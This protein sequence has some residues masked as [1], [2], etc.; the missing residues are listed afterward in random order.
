MY[1]P[2]D[3]E[4][5]VREHP[6]EAS[7]ALA[8]IQIGDE[9]P[10]LDAEG[11]NAAAR[12]FLS[13]RGEFW[14][15]RLDERQLLPAFARALTARGLE[16]DLGEDPIEITGVPPEVAKAF[17]DRA[18]QFRCRI[19]R[20]GAVSGSGVLVGPSTVLTAWHVVGPAAPYSPQGPIPAL[21]VLL[22]DGRRLRATLAEGSP[23]SP[24]EFESRLPANDNA[25]NALHDVALL[26]L[27]EP[28]GAQFGYATVSDPPVPY[29]RPGPLLLVHYPNGVDGGLGEGVTERI[30]GLRARV[31]HTVVSADGSSGGGCFDTRRLLV[32]VHQGRRPDNRGRFVPI[33]RFTDLIRRAIAADAAPPAMWSLDGTPRSPLVIGRTDFLSAYAAALAPGPVRG[34]RVRRT[35]PLADAAGLPFSHEM[36]VGLA[37]RDQGQRVVRVSFADRSPDV[38]ET[39]LRRLRDEGLAAGQARERPGVATGESAPEAV[40]ADV[41]KRAALLADQA[42]AAAGLTLWLF[43]DE[44]E[45]AFGDRQR[46]TLEGFIAQALRLGSLRLVVA[47]YEAAPIPGTEYEPGSAPTSG[48][49]GLMVEYVA[50]FDRRDAA[51]TLELAAAAAG[52]QLNAVARD[53]AV[54]AALAGRPEV[55]GVFAPWLAADA[56]EALRPFVAAMFQED[57]HG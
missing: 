36:L 37:A 10:P 7:D 16:I 34:I 8:A 42:A 27:S 56:A 53:A 39:I 55:N 22:S 26:R 50:G 41:G 14:V 12:T 1:V 29:R 33:E 5:A 18:A 32:G 45:T 2:E 31:G 51:S 9:R 46:A 49:P 52:A 15:Q 4:A 35:D 21:E 57:P 20:E 24:D 3:L 13:D 48:A 23:C 47:G 25:V 54:E 19:I 38:A 43:I 11:L 28:A 17:I 6:L 40:G 44:P 30:R